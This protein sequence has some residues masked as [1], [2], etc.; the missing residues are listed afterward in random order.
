MIEAVLLDADAR[1]QEGQSRV[2]R[3]VLEKLSHVLDKIDDLLDE[4][5]TRSELKKLTAASGFKDQVCRFFSSDM[6]PVVS[7]CRDV[8]QVKDV[9]KELD[10]ITKNRS[11]FDN[12][13]LSKL[14]KPKPHPQL[15]L[16][17]RSHIISEE[18]VGKIYSHSCCSGLGLIVVFAIKWTIKVPTFEGVVAKIFRFGRSTEVN[19][20]ADPPE[21]S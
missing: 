17:T 6:H 7:L 2:Q 12:Y 11:L 19:G 9:S 21:A 20:Q 5:A 10:S 3:L 16:E 18:V 8:R 14:T 1:T 13:L 15:S 4:K